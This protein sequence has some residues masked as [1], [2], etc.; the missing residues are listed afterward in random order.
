MI[1]HN[2]TLKAG[3][4]RL[5]SPW[6]GLPRHGLSRFGLAWLACGLFW[7]MIVLHFKTTLSHAL[8]PLLQ[9]ELG[10]LAPQYQLTALALQPLPT[11]LEISVHASFIT[12]DAMI[13]GGHY[14]PAKTPLESS[15]LLGHLWQPLIIIFSLINAIALGRHKNIFILHL[16][17]L[18]C[19]A[20]LIMLDVPFVLL[21]ALQDLLAP[22]AFSTWVLWMNFINGG[23]RL[24]LAIATALFIIAFCPPSNKLAQ[25]Q[26]TASTPKQHISMKSSS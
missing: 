12:R 26:A 13:I 18:P 4:P 10:W 1:D 2:A 6:S 5:G 25:R 15:T 23:G 7:L 9:W 16:L 24:G 21:G 22:H 3:F 19:T 20:L 8:L 11:G 17:C 14:L